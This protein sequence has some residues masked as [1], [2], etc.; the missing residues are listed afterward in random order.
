LGTELDVIVPR[1]IGAP[2]EPEL[3]VGA[4]MHDGSVYL[5]RDIVDALRVNKAYLDQEMARQQEE[6]VRRLR[7]YRGD[8]EYPDVRQRVVVLVDDGIATGATVMA[9]LRWLRENAAKQV[10][11]ACPVAPPE[12][13]ARL[14]E[15]ADDVV[16]ISTPSPFHAI[17]QFYENFE[18]VSD[19]QVVDLLNRAR[20]T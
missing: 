19:D 2:G 6:A 10:I 3:A 11:V 4:V 7:L 1:K 9:A 18:Q 13:V 20:A 16:C 14:G 8:R 12:T 5:N 15:E 17:G